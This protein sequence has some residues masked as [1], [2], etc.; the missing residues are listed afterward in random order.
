MN[1]GVDTGF[2]PLGSCTMKYNP[3]VNEEVAALAGFAL[4]HPLQPQGLSQGALSL[5]YCLERY[6]AEITGMDHVTLQPAAGAHGELTAMMMIHAYF[7]DRGEKRSKVIIP[8]TAHG[9]NPAS[10]NMCGFTTVPLKSGPFGYI[11]TKAIRDLMDEDVA[12]I[13]ITNPNTLGIFECNAGDISEIVHGKGGLVY[14]DGANLNALMGIVRFG[15]MGSDL[16][17]VN[18]HKT[19]STPHGGGG[20]GS[21][22]LAVKDKLAPYLPIPIVVKEGETYRLSEDVSRTIGKVKGFYGNF[23]IC[24]RAYAY[25]LAMGGAGLK[26]ASVTAAVN[27]NY[28]KSKLKKYYHLP[29][30]TPCLHECVFT[31][32]R[33]QSNHVTVLD[34][35]K[36]LIDYG[37]HPPTIY[38]PLVVNGALMIEPTETESRRTLDQFIEAMIVIAEEA[39][40]SPEL[41]RRAPVKS[42]ITRVDEVLAARNPVLRWN[43]HDGI[44]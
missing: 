2:Y 17:H 14:C 5:M 30:E 4:A 18:L 12:A 31:D 11:E 3:K 8:D 26:R 28:I 9:T 44:D 21:G 20:P 15:D 1:Y 22:P 39:E 10:V 7:A 27:A 33:Q 32:K 6:L 36:R 19:F 35:A 16:A 29:Y 23:L 34:I 41:L 42:I 25:I 24:V 38:F 13:M 40:L 43:P 37:F